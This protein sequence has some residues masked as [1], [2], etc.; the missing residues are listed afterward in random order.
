MKKTL[1]LVVAL[2]MVFA[3]VA[4]FGASAEEGYINRE[5][6]IYEIDTA[7]TI[8]GVIND[9]EY[10]LVSFWPADIEMKSVGDFVD[11]IEAYFYMCYDKDNLYY[12]IKTQCE[13]HVAMMD[14]ANNHFIFNAHHVMTLIV[15]DDPTKADYPYE[16]DKCDWSSLYNG[17]YGF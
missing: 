8:D 6:S 4:S 10:H 12:A 9:G 16:A 15:P 14:N 7:P 3:A 1:A 13:E 11:N 5:F 17:N 2:V